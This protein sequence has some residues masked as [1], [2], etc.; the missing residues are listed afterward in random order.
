MNM[1]KYNSHDLCFLARIVLETQTP[2]KVGSGRGNVRTDAV[3][4]R[5]ANGLPY[6]PATTLK[7]LLRHALD[8][9][10]ADRV[11]G[12]QNSKDGQGSWL[13]ISEAKIVTDAD[14]STADGLLNPDKVAD[15]AYLSRFREMP[16]REH[17]RIGHRGVT[18]DKGKFDEEI[19][20]KGVRF[21]FEMELRAD[22]QGRA[23]IQRL[24]NIMKD[25]TFR[26]GGGSRKG[27]GK[28]S[29]EK[30]L[31]KEL[32]FNNKE[33]FA[34]YIGKS[35]SLAKAWKLFE[36]YT[37]ASGDAEGQSA[38]ADKTAASAAAKPVSYKLE[39][40]PVDFIFFSSG[41][42]DPETGA[43]NAVVKEPFVSWQQDK[44]K[45]ESET[46]SLVVP[47]SSVKGAIA[48]RTAFYYN[49]LTGVNTKNI[50]SDEK[51]VGKDNVAVKAL[52]GSEGDK[53]GASIKDGTKRRGHV[54]F[55][56]VVRKYAEDVQAK[57][58][59]HVKID[60]FTGGAITGALFDERPLYARAETI[61]LEMT[62][63]PD[64]ETQGQHV[65]EA[66]EQALKD[67]CRGTLPLGGSVNRG[68]GCFHGKLT[69]DNETIFDYDL[70]YGQN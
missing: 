47:A 46:T 33:D 13:S 3:I 6:I 14:G 37:T 22:G 56:D 55:S 58:I 41:L 30:V 48:H 7:G 16:V 45:W 62:L 67:V 70:G 31:Y 21:C 59:N 29:V 1:K 61:T 34:A 53:E 65:V 8:G 28:I 4:N 11:M 19:V 64:S 15:D 39:L 50:K 32:D 42:G 54:L 36:P 63:L 27:F 40:K 12:W 9:D 17:V 68:N 69:R 52:F 60:R 10:T 18:V 20:P 51:P 44:P 26:I 23:D 57:T 38:N 25:E 66:F 49:L 24:L 2:L 35:S 43:D 5:D